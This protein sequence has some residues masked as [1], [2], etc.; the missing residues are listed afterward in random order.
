MHFY[1]IANSGLHVKKGIGNKILF[2]WFHA[3]EKMVVCADF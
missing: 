2:A 3:A 1:K